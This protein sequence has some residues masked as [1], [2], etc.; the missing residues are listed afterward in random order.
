M[1]FLLRFAIGDHFFLHAGRSAAVA[2]ELHRECALPLRQT[3]KVCRVAKRFAQGDLA[4]NHHHTG[5]LHI[6][7]EDDAAPRSYVAHDP[8]LEL[9]RC[10]D[11]HV[12]DG[13]QQDRFGLGHELPEAIFGAD[14]ERQFR[15]VDV[16]V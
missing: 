8:A 2:F 16:V 10:F 11:L 13:F 4:T 15:T 1:A 12:H 3:T 9:L 7:G 14:L 6:G 5:V